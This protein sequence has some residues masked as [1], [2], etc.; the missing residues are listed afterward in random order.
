MQAS[1]RDQPFDADSIF[2]MTGDPFDL[3]QAGN[4]DSTHPESR[5]TLSL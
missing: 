2:L 5:G 4:P 1:A 3:F